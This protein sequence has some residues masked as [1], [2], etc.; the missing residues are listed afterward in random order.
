MPDH[1]IAVTSDPLVVLRYL[2][3]IVV[4]LAAPFVLLLGLPAL[5]YLA[6]MGV[7]VLQR[8]IAVAAERYA[9]RQSDVRAAVG[10]NVGG[11]LARTWLVGL[12]IVAVGLA[13]SRQ[14]GLMAALLM[15]VA[16]SLYFATSLFMRPLDRR[17]PRA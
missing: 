12:T 8:A 2:D 5:G 15:L 10:L 1:H 17:P 7:W 16:F 6:G 4:V 9:R 14:D 3:V 11:L 13:G